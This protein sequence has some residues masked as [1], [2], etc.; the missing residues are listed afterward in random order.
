MHDLKG[1]NVHQNYPKVNFRCTW[2]FDAEILIVTGLDPESK[3]Q[4]RWMVGTTSKNFSEI[5]FSIEKHT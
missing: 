4:L 5:S 2:I 3:L 1:S